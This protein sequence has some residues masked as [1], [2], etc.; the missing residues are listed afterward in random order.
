MDEIP[1]L[2]DDGHQAASPD[3]RLWQS[4]II[5]YLRDIQNSIAQLKR[6]SNGKAK[7]II[8]R[9]EKDYWLADS[10]WIEDICFFSDI[11]YIRLKVAKL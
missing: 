6:N 1:E 2:E 10:D 8:G 5:V 4:V 9:L 11:D 3:K 7:K